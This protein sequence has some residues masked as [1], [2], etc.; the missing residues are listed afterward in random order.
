MKPL[1]VV[2]LITLA[3]AAPLSA[4]A[5]SGPA[6][7]QPTD[8]REDFAYAVGMQAV[9]YG[10]PLML[11]VRQRYF[12]VEKPMGVID[13]PINTWFY[14]PRVPNSDDKYGISPS[15]NLYYSVAWFDV[16]K[17]PLVITVPDAGSRYYSIQMME[18]YSDI[19]G[20]IGKR[21]TENKAGNYL[22]VGP[23]WKGKVPKGITAIRRSPT[24]KGALLMRIL[25][26]SRDNLDVPKA[27]ARKTAI[28]PLS[29]WLARKPFSTT[30]RDVV[31]YVPI[32]SGD[33]FWFYRNVNRGM[34]ENPPPA[35][36]A[37]LLRAFR[38]VG[39]GP[40]LGEDFAA[41][42][43]AIQRGLKRAEA[44]GIAMVIKAAVSGANT[45]IVNHWAYGTANWGRTAKSNDY[46]T[47]ASTQGHAGWQEHWIEEVVKLRAHHDSDGQPLNGVNRYELRF[48]SDQLPVVGAFWSVTLYDDKYNL[49]ANSLNRFSL[50]SP[51]LAKMKRE[52]DG[53]LVMLIQAD[54]P[55]G[56]HKANWLPAPRGPFNLFIRAYLPDKGLQEQS[57]APPPVRKLP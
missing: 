15:D 56:E 22:L 4:Q 51:E 31:D 54:P 18:M 57:Y 14:S 6:S 39:I 38:D 10:Y 29:Y 20:Y 16:S 21:E 9:V 28:K 33:P 12:Q 13:T 52:A 40:G 24:P 34:T 26:D 2:S 48:A 45:K 36:D 5:D 8:W 46:L 32:Q 11:N 49:S 50:G 1:N 27:L 41:L 3:L 30:E 35:S 44:D 55:E 25:I 42:D 7:V 53:S 37:P 17:E 19:F 43:P 23:D 47:R